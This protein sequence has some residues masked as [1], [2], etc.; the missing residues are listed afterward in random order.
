MDYCEEYSGHFNK[1]ACEHARHYLSGL[2]GRTARKNIGQIGEDVTGS[3]YQGMQQ[4]ISNSPWDHGRVMEQVAGQASAILGAHRDCALYIDETS[5]VKKGGGSVGV[6]KQYC[7]RPGKIENCQVGVFASLGRGERAALVDF[8]LFLPQSWAQD[9]RR[10]AKAGIPQDSRKHQTKNELALQMI[11]KA[12]ERKLGHQWIGADENHGN[13]R[14]LTDAIDD[15]GETYLMDIAHD[16]RVWET[17]P[18]PGKTT[19]RHK[20]TGASKLAGRH[21][22][23]ESRQV[24]TRQSTRGKINVR[25][26]VR[27]VWVWAGGN[28]RVRERLLIVRQEADGA[29]KHSLSNAPAATAWERLACMQGQRYF[30]ERAFEDGKSELGLADYEVRGWKGWHHHMTLCCMAQ[31]FCLKERIGYARDYPLLS[32]RDIVGLLAYYLPRKN[33]DKAAV[34]ADLRSRHEARRK[35]ILRRSKPDGNLTK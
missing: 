16:T 6:Q 26:W 11:K 28:D 7:G 5:F 15:M 30:I 14:E 27:T 21:F 4:F 34:L 35:D 1:S 17:K 19:P 31:L 13:S 9:P 3:D 10:C 32:V 33:R 8:R 24:T 20:Q 29:F 18:E 25:I 23:K 12:R 22:E 2:L